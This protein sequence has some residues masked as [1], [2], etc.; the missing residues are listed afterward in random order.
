MKKNKLSGLDLKQLLDLKGYQQLKVSFIQNLTKDKR[1]IGLNTESDTLM[2]DDVH[3]PFNAF[4][5]VKDNQELNEFQRS[6]LKYLVNKFENEFL[7]ELLKNS[8]ENY[9]KAIE[10]NRLEETKYSVEEKIGFYDEW[11]SYFIELLVRLEKSA[12]L[13]DSLKNLTIDTILRIKD[14]LSDRKDEL[15]HPR[16]IKIPFN[17]SRENLAIIFS[18]FYKNEIIHNKLTKP[19]L[20]RFI[21]NS[22]L[23]SKTEEITEIRNLIYQYTKPGKL[24]DKKKSELK[25]ILFKIV[26]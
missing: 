21:E 6:S 17:L 3:I 13:N 19:E 1:Y 15:I 2:V 16:E 10:A 22:F 26:S 7:V 4:M 5:D 8:I 9:K 25:D 11:E 12:H 24:S 23:H 18:L 20:A 14:E